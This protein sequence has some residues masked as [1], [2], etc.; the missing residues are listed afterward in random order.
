MIDDMDDLELDFQTWLA[1]GMDAGWCGPPVCYT[2]DGLPMSDEE[3]FEE[4]LHGEPPCMHII[5][6]Y[7]GDEHRKQIEDSHSPS[8]WR[9][10]GY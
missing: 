10:Q 6:L 5:R 1:V 3:W 4:D 7:E 8:V 2:H 9:K